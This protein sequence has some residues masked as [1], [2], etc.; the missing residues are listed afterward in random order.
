MSN[1]ISSFRQSRTKLNMFNLFRLCRK[2][3]ISLDIVAESGNIV[4]E[5]GNIVAKN[6]NNVEATFDIVE[7][8]V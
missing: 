4:A 7:R 8:I 6:G 2:D 5:T 1:E 3:E